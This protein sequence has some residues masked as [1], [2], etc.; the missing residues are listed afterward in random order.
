VEDNIDLPLHPLVTRRLTAGT[1]IVIAGAA[2]GARAFYQTVR[3]LDVCDG[4]SWVTLSVLSSGSGHPT[5]CFMATEAY[6]GM[7]N[8]LSVKVP[9]V[10]I[11][12]Q[13]DLSS[14]VTPALAGW[15][16]KV[17]GLCPNAERQVT[18]PLWVLCM[19]NRP[20]LPVQLAALTQAVSVGVGFYGPSGEFKSF[21]GDVTAKLRSTD[22]M[23]VINWTTWF[24]AIPLL[25]PVFVNSHHTESET[26]DNDFEDVTADCQHDHDTGSPPK[27]TPQ[28]NTQPA[29]P[30]KRK[31]VDKTPQ[32]EKPKRATKSADGGLASFAARVSAASTPPN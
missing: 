24:K 5:Y 18:D 26:E 32:L 15:L 21:V 9:N 1:P 31:T 8:K 12:H 20:D 13:A 4:W 22:C 11:V 6:I 2:T 29:P 10:I 30:R 27:K 16:L 25:H 3:C 23:Y 14:R 7:P 28:K 17:L 19:T